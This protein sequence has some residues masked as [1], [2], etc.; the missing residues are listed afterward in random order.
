MKRV[1]GRKKS[2]S[3]TAWLSAVQ[4]I[5]SLIT[6]EEVELRE[7]QA[8][9]RIYA[10]VSKYG[11]GNLAYGWSGGK[12]SIVLT[13]LCNAAGVSRGVFGTCSLE[14]PSFLQWVNENIPEGVEP[15]DS[16]R[17]I[18][19]LARHMDMLFPTTSAMMAKWYAVTH[20]R[21]QRSYY[22]R[23]KL[24]GMILGRRDI[25]GNQTHGG[26]MVD[27]EGR[28][29]ISP[30]FDWEHEVVLGCIHYRKIPAPPIYAWKNGY[31]EGTHLWPMRSGK[32]RDHRTVWGEIYE[33]DKDAVHYAAS[34][35]DEAKEFLKE[36]TG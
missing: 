25:D 36:V 27:R 8:I 16:G 11:A 20:H 3:N 15:E 32:G 19:W 17:D 35:I 31:W 7:E 33:I 5:E 4:N 30:I 34:L 21:S 10:C 12:D 2:I 26:E 9:E 13:H 28:V 22:K 14:Y 29:W 1:L 24:S 18:H 6:H 23:N